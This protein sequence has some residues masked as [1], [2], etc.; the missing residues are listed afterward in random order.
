MVNKKGNATVIIV[1]IALLILGL[2]ALM[3]IR[4]FGIGQNLFTKP[5]GTTGVGPEVPKD[6][7]VEALNSQSDSDE[8]DTIEKDTN[9]TNLDDL[10]QGIDQ[11][12]QD[13]SSL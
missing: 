10:D 11:V 1:I 2:I 13:L 9:A 12:D 8:I 4:G 3:A 6:S 5:P 7:Q